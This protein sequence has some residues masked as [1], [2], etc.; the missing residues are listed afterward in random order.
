MEITNF[1]EVGV[2]IQTRNEGHYIAQSIA[3]C[4]LAVVAVG[5]ILVRSVAKI[6]RQNTERVAERVAR[7]ATAQV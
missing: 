2:E 4:S 1:E 5:Y 7:R 6:Q 3:L